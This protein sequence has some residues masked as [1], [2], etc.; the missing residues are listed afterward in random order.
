[1]RRPVLV[2]ALA[3]ALLCARG[4]GA[5][6]ADAPAAAP[7]PAHRPS[8]VESGPSKAVEAAWPGDGR[9]DLE[10]PD[11]VWADVV[12][13][14]GLP[15]PTLGFS[16]EQMASYGRD[17]RITRPIAMQFRDVRAVPRTAGKLSDDLLGAVDD[18]GELVRMVHGLSDAVAGRNFPRPK[19]AE[20]GPAWLP[21]TTT[22][23]DALETVLARLGTLAGGR[24]VPRSDEARTAWRALPEAVQRLVVRVLVGTAEALPWLRVAF[25]EPFLVEAVGARAREEVTPARLLALASRPWLDEDEALTPARSRAA[26]DALGKVDRDY[27]ALGSVVFA[28]HLGVAL[29]EWKAVRATVDLKAVEGGALWVDTPFGAVRVLG[30]GDD[31]VDGAAGAAMLV[32]DLGGKDRFVGRV[33]TPAWPTVPVSTVIDLGGDDVYDGGELA[34]AVACGLFGVGTVVDVAGDDQYTV[35]ASG[36][37]CAWYGTGT[38]LDLEGKD[39]YVVRTKWGQGA[40]HVGA[41]LLVDLAGDDAYECAEQSQGFGSTWGGGLLLDLA[42]NDAYVA[43]D[44]GAKSDLYL[45]QSVAMSQGCGFGRRADLGDGHSLAGGFGVL[46][47]AAGDDRYHA[48]CWAQGC[49]YW[50]AVGILE[51][52]AGNDVY[53]NGKYSL[54]A[55]AHFAVGCQVDLAGDDRY[56]QGVETAVNQYQGHARDGSIGVSIDG[57]GD[58]RYQLRNH[59]GGSGDLC[60]VGLFWDRRG[61]DVYQLR[62]NP[63]GAPNGWTETPPMGSATRADRTRTFRDELGTSGVFL[64]TGG[65]DTFTWENLP[66][67]RTGLP[68]GLPFGADGTTWAYRAGPRCL[69]VGIDVAVF[70]PRP[71]AP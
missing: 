36:L 37:G 34:G 46:V 2:A 58:D 15:G 63:L 16:L 48:Q 32:L 3:A 8:V 44:D 31:T 11:A 29:A 69:G 27:L 66:A 21:A 55:G 59:T 33:G 1:M 6:A 50:W 5:R 43:R 47:D 9:A 28:L 40:A 14:L 24:D 20:W 42:G 64:D 53:E 17:A 41:G 71:K 7:A 13:R 19:G 30:T 45:G 68:T 4:V 57:D 35:A 67:D 60:S 23:A 62:W 10:V 18:V 38:L 70:P 65:R 25:D 49:G 51:D 26:F 52:R 22:P 12:A 54:G 39:R 61:D 56:N